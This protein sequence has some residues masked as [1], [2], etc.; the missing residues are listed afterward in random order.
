[1]TETQARITKEGKHYEILVDLD[2]ALK[3]KKGEGDINAVV[4]TDY[5]FNNIKSGEHASAGDMEKVFGSSV[6]L[7]VCEKIIK[8]G[9]VVLPTDYKNEEQDQKYKQIVDF[10]V[11][12]AVSP[13]GRPYTP[14]RIMSALKEAHVNVKNK[15]IDSQIQ[16]I[17]DDLSKILPIKVEMKRL[18]ITVPAQHTG[19]AYGVIN[20]FKESEEWLGNGDLVA[21]LSIP[22]GLEMDFYDKLNNVT[23]GSALSEEI[24]EK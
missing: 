15:P 1:M 18:K 10:L 24:K 8:Q 9:E 5:V 7:E 13:E 2:A 20:E 14:D 17:I 3:F 11:R 19:K 21:I 6:F 16:D 4:L 22:A 23:H 12:N